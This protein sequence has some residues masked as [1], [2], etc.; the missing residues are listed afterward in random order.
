MC[1]KVTRFSTQLP[2]RH[3][4]QPEYGDEQ[5]DA[6]RDTAEPSRETKFSGSN[7]DR[8]IFIF[9]V[10]LNHFAR[11]NLRRTEERKYRWIGYIRV[12]VTTEYTLIKTRHS[13]VPTYL[14]RETDTAG[15]STL[16]STLPCPKNGGGY[17]NTSTFLQNCTPIFRNVP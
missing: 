5:V 8:E 13:R 2:G 16:T 11:Q 6:K 10:Q 17:P 9:P 12:N 1:P 7:A 4:I 3:Q 14:Q 15:W